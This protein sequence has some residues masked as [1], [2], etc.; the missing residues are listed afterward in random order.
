MANLHKPGNLEQAGWDPS[1]NLQILPVNKRTTFYLVAAPDADVFTD[2]EDTAATSAGDSDDKAA[3][4]DGS[5]SGWEKSQT[6]RKVTVAAKGLGTTQLHAQVDGVDVIA[7]LTIRV[8]SNPDARQVGAAKAEVTPEL[9]SEIQ[10][11]PLREAVLRVAEDQMNSHV[12]ETSGFGVYNMDAKLDWCGGFVYWCWDQACAI[13]GVE[14]PFG[15]SNTVLWS[16]QRAIHWAMQDTTPGQLL[17]YA[18]ES[19][20]DGKGRQEFHDIGWNGY[21]L[22]PGDVVLLRQTN[23]VGWKHVCMVQSTSGRTVLTQNGNQGLPKSIKLVE[24]SLDTKLG[25]GSFALVFIAVMRA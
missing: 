1:R 12:S 24:R 6:I 9:R 22:K 18:G 15:G 4:R 7:P 20:M 21:D 25:D 14:N 10:G 8:T 5:L 3:H 17:R 19:P 13:Q 2:D 16:P 11:L 23:A